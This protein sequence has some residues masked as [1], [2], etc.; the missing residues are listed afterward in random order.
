MKIN[1]VNIIYSRTVQMRQFEPAQISISIKA[2][3]DPGDT[4]ANVL[5]TIKRTAREEVE[6]ERQRLLN[7]RQEAYD[8]DK[9]K[10]A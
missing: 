9:E 10:A 7:E 4:P 8:N 1:E 3:V 6:N 2:Q 5:K